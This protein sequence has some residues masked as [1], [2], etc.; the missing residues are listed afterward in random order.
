MSRPVPS[1]TPGQAHGVR[2]ARPQVELDLLGAVGGG[3]Q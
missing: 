2:L 3:R 1:P